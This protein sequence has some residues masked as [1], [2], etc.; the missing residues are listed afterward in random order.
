M[1]KP[2][3]ERIRPSILEDYISQEHL[4][5]TRWSSYCSIQFRYVILNDLLGAT[6]NR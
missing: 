3:A 2:L 1:N 4:V 5:G 6:R